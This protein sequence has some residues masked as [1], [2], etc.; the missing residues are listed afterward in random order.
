M[1]TCLELSCLI[2]LYSYAYKEKVTHRQMKLLS[3]KLLLNHVYNKCLLQQ[4]RANCSF[5]LSHMLF[6]KIFLL[7]QSNYEDFSSKVNQVHFV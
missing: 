3:E 6:I 4:V 1:N 5:T 2:L 7:I